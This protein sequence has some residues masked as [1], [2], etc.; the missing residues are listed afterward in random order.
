MR[1]VLTVLLVMLMWRGAAAATPPVAAIPEASLQCRQAVAL[2]ERAA[3]VPA[4]LMA[5][6]ARIESGR[7]DG[8]GGVHP[9][10]WTINVEGEGHVYA[11]KAEAIA[12]VRMYQ[13]RG[14]RSIDVGCMQ[15][16][17]MY[18]PTAFSSL[19]EAFDPMANARYAAKFLSD[20]YAQTRDWSR[21][22]AMYHSA[23]PGVG[24]NYQRKVYAVLPDENSKAAQYAGGQAV[25]G[26][27]WSGNVWSQNIWN[28]PGATPTGSGI[29][30]TPPVPP[31]GGFQLT[32]R[33]DSARVIPAPQGAAG[34]GLE[35][36]RAT[37]IPVTSRV[38]SAAR[39]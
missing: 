5:A 15:V 32:N 11:S 39:L 36:Y 14:A 23:T 26:N 29:P 9:W 16:N 38:A 1:L 22:T 24:E 8:Q 27:V 25:A 34:R 6:I 13:A 12:A 33:A 30:R 18:H 10:P 20:L 31:T 4:R 21:A 2:V 7:S 35:A 17:L 28:T 37:P 3:G 19:D